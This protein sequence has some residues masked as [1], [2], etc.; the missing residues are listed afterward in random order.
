[1]V[2]LYEMIEDVGIEYVMTLSR[3]RLQKNFVSTPSNDLIYYVVSGL[4]PQEL[5]DMVSAQVL[6]RT[7]KRVKPLD[8][9]D[10][11]SYLNDSNEVGEYFERTTFQQKFKQECPERIWREMMEHPKM[12]MSL[13]ENQYIT[14]S[15]MVHQFSG[16]KLH[17]LVSMR[18]FKK[19]FAFLFDPLLTLVRH[20]LFPMKK[21][22]TF[23]GKEVRHEVCLSARK[24]YSSDMVTHIMSFLV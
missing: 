22:L 3:E 9:M 4:S 18:R 6:K 12:I 7:M 17:Q 11:I 14:P 19:V 5:I 15:M 16:M 10:F 23:S 13:L 21:G 2:H 8:L 24:S 1:M 20:S